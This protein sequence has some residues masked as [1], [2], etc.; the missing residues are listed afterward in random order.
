MPTLAA[1]ETKMGHPVFGLVDQREEAGVQAI[2]AA[3]YVP[4]AA[5]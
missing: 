2:L 1:S 5:E 4:N 3:D